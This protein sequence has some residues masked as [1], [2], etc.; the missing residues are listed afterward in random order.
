MFCRLRDCVRDEIATTL[1]DGGGRARQIARSVCAKY[2]DLIG[3]LGER[4]A[5]D[6]VTRLVNREI[7]RW[8]AV[9]TSMR[10]QLVLPGM[11]AHVRAD[12]PAAISVPSA[13]DGDDGDPIYRPLFGP[14]C[15]TV[16][17]L[18]A[19]VAAL[20][21]SIADDQRKAKALTQLLDLLTSAGASDDVPVSAALQEACG[22]TR[23]QVNP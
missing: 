23:E 1:H 15:A 14:K 22:S 17:E 8:S 12:L 13:D 19:A 6:A 18:R 4:L 16:G 10:E 20:W 2:P 9:G 21:K 3:V 11:L 7:K 5:E